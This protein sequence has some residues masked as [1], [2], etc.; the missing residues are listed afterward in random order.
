MAPRKATAPR[1]VKSTTHAD[2]RTNIPTEELR[3]FVADDERNPIPVVYERPLLHPRDPDADP[4]LI[5]RGMTA[6]EQRGEVPLPEGVRIHQPD[7]L[8]SQGASSSP[9]PFEYRGKRYLQEVA[10]TGKS[11]ARIQA[12][13]NRISRWQAVRCLRDR[14]PPQAW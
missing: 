11:T 5:W 14:F 9:Q 13:A 10:L 4:Q 8:Q 3:D 12:T 2:K 7:N 6:V 1:Q